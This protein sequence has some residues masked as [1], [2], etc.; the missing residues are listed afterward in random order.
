[1]SADR[2]AGP[3]VSAVIP[4]YNYARYVADAVE[5]ALAQC[6]P[7]LEVV[8]VDDGSTDATADVLRRFGGRIRYVRQE[9]RGLSAARNTGIRVARGRYLAFLDSDDLW[10]PGKLSEQAA[11]L[12]AEPEVGLVYGEALIVDERSTEEPTLHSHW[13][14]HPSGWVWPAL[15]RQ[16]VVPSPTPMVR[17]EVFERVGP[18][19]E[20]LTAC[21][22]WDMWIR[23]SRV[24]PFAYVDRV[25]AKYRRHHANMSLDYERM[26][27]NGLRVLEKA[28]ASPR[29]SPALRRLRRAVLSQY[30]AD[31]GI[32]RFQSGRYG[33]ARSD[34]RLR[35][36]QP[37]VDGARGVVLVRL[38]PA[39][40]DK[41]PVAQILR[42][43]APV[44]VDD[45]GGGRLV[46]ADDLAQ[47]LGIEPP[48][49]NGRV[50]EVTEHH[51]ELA[52]LRLADIVGRGRERSRRRDRRGWL[53]SRNV[54]G[55]LKG[56]NGLARPDQAL[57]VLVTRE[58]PE[59][60]LLPRL[61]QECLV[62]VEDVR[63][64]SIGHAA[65]SLQIGDEGRQRRVHP[66]PRVRARVRSGGRADRAGGLGKGRAAGFAEP[67]APA[68]PVT[69]PRTEH[70]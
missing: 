66:R 61:V 30:R 51:R 35:D 33:E 14:P 2:L 5:S 10:L 69:A 59:G 24:C 27:A 26:M 3:R 58:P 31:R 43:V 60:E 55:R 53:R 52:P 28:F 32:N 11:W 70:A 23:V 34:N 44:A 49:E 4:T 36:L 54:R 65:L 13:A 62:A 25:V 40:V 39:E 47:V 9:N 68:D 8:V 42:D 29:R 22:D 15:V 67:R 48:G 50:G 46:R 7:G 56:G 16:N 38:R 41:Q 63:D 20:T 45:L 17:R 21:E 12:D 19:D 37:R 6:L 1:V 64:R 57:P 18:F